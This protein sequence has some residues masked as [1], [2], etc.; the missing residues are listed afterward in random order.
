MLAARLLAP[1]LHAVLSL[2]PHL[3]PS[4]PSHPVCSRMA[5]R[6]AVKRGS[7]IFL[8]AVK[9]K[10]GGAAFELRLHVGDFWQI[11]QCRQVNWSLMPELNL[12]SHM[13][14]AL[15]EISDRRSWHILTIVKIME[16]AGFSSSRQ[17]LDVVKG[18]IWAEA[19]FADRVAGLC[20]EIDDMITS[21]SSY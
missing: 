21:R 3:L 12:W 9:A 11:S 19:L 6:E 10:F 18:I 13:I 4:S 15:A 1:A 16:C 7:L 8:T 2:E 5:A 17:A 14:A 20:Y